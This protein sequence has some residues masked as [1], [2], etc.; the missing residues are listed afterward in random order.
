MRRGAAA[1][2]LMPGFDNTLRPHSLRRATLYLQG[3]RVRGGSAA[4]AD[5]ERMLGQGSGH[6]GTFLLGEAGYEEEGYGSEN[7]VVPNGEG[8]EEDSDASF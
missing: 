3:N 8:E 5:L 6:R 4:M 7:F 1:L 2:A